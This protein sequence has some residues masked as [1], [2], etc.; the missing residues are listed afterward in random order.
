MKR[1]LVYAVVFLALVNTLAFTQDLLDEN[2]PSQ[3]LD[4]CTALKTIL[5]FK[6][7]LLTENSLE[8]DSSFANLITSL[9]GLSIKL[10]GTGVDT[11]QLDRHLTFLEEK[12]TKLRSDRRTYHESLKAAQQLECTPNVSNLTNHLKDIKVYADTVK[13]GFKDLNT[14]FSQVILND[15]RELRYA[16]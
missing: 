4:E 7:R 3:T 5:E 8:L 13:E 2:I 12:L 1:L 14:Y 15:L 6:D 9:K 16:R 10:R 11:L